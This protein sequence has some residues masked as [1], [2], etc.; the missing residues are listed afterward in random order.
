MVYG[1]PKDVPR[2]TAS[3][4]ILRDKVFNI[5]KNQKYDGC[6]RV[7]ASMAY[8]I[9]TAGGA[10]KNEIMQSKELSEELHKPIITIFEKRKVHS[11]CI[12]NICGA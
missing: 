5:T 4:K 9:L 12:D 1:D 11:S 8:R 7:L 3:D 10:V 6:Q 2:R